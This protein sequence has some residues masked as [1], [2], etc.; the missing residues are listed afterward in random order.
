VEFRPRGSF[1]A[2]TNMI[3]GGAHG[4]IPGQWTDDT[5][6]ALCLASSLVDCEAF[7]LKDQIDRYCAWFEDGYWSSTGYCFDIGRTVLSA[8]HSYRRTGNPC[9]GSG[10]A[11][12]AGNGCIMRLAP[13]AMFFYPDEE[14]AMRFSAESA[15]TTHQVPECLDAATILGRTIVRAL[16]GLPKDAVLEPLAL[17]SESP[18]LQDVAR[19]CY[20]SKRYNQIRGSGYVTECL[21]AALWCFAHTDS[22]ENAVLKAVNLGGDADTTAA[23]CGQIAG[24][25]YGERAIPRTWLRSLH[26]AWEIRDLSDRLLR[27]ASSRKID[28]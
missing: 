23:V 17:A 18:Q 27:L 22:F 25:F 13:V 7:D 3:G 5:S 10:H 6:M 1:P 16:R 2:V 19:G 26:L 11:R 12:T 28:L 15:T 4:L 14:A 9:A 21:E 8:L 20:L 24:S